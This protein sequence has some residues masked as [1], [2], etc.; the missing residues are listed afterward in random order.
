MPALVKWSVT[1][2]TITGIIKTRQ[3]KN[4]DI[5]ALK[6]KQSH[7][8]THTHTHLYIEKYKQYT[9]TGNVLIAL[10]LNFRFVKRCCSSDTNLSPIQRKT[11]IICS[12]L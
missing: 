3:G 5:F 8:H 12:K 4:E 9:N 7:T 6:Q 11:K 2:K 10:G 1:V